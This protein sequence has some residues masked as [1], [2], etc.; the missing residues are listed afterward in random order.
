MQLLYDYGYYL[1]YQNDAA[2]TGTLHNDCGYTVTGARVVYT[3][4]AWTCGN[5]GPWQGTTF[6]TG[7]SPGTIAYGGDGAF[8]SGDIYFW[9]VTCK[10]DG[11]DR[12]YPAFEGYATWRGQGWSNSGR[13]FNYSGTDNY[14]FQF[15]NSINGGPCPM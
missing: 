7:T 15:N 11:T 14:T 9:C 8:D 5:T 3:P 6:A 10:T 12:G 13:D 4:W 1:N 2:I